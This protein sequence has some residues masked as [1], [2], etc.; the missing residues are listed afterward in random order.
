MSVC[1]IIKKLDTRAGPFMIQQI[2]RDRQ[3]SA[4]SEFCD[5]GELLQACSLAELAVKKMR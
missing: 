3:Y 4:E 5:L 1:T 2:P